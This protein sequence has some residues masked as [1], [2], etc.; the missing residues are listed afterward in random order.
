MEP[1]QKLAEAV[2]K[3]GLHKNSFET[4]KHGDI[5]EY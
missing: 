4:V 2:E 5:Y 1:K 3:F